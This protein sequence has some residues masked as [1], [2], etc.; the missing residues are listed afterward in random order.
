V[1]SVLHGLRS[2]GVPGLLAVLKR[3]GPAADAPLS[4]PAPGWTL[5][6]DLPARAAGLAAALDAADELVHASGGRVY[7][8]KDARL[9]PELVGDMYP[10]LAR[11][12]ALREA[13]DPNRTFTSDLARR[14]NL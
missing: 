1:A 8:A 12:R 9:R 5:A 2:A 7:F 4:F 10:D 3:F 11:W 6:V 13:A 14:L